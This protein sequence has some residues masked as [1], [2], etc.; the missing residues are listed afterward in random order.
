MLTLQTKAKYDCIVQAGMSESNEK[1]TLQ[2]LSFFFEKAGKSISGP[3]LC[4]GH[5]EQARTGHKGA[6]G[7]CPVGRLKI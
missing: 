5:L 2:C 6:A 7:T 3:L 4:A 1:F